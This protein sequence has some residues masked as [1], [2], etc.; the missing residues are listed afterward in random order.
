MLKKLIQYQYM[1]VDIGEDFKIIG[2]QGIKRV[3]AYNSL[4]DFVG[5]IIIPNVMV[6]AGIIIFFYAVFGGFTIITNAG[7]PDKQKEGTQAITNALLGFALIFG[8]Y[9]IIQII[10]ALTGYDIFNPGI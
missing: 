8:A 4:W 1:A 7:N 10:K 6:I 5:Q 3:G 2:D 9:W